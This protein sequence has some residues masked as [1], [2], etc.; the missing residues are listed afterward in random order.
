MRSEYMIQ[1]VISLNTW[2]SLLSEGDT[3]GVS[4]AVLRKLHHFGGSQDILGMVYKNLVESIL[5]L[6][7]IRTLGCQI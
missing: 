7:M 3:E 2:M 6:D 1:I 5:S 4:S